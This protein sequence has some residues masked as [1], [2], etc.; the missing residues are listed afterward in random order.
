VAV[1]FPWRKILLRSVSNSTV[2]ISKKLTQIVQQ[3]RI[4]PS[5]PKLKLSLRLCSCLSAFQ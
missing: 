2:S 3:N 4:F 1:G 5:D